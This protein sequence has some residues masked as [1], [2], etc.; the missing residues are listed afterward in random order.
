VGGPIAFTGTNGND[1][2]NFNSTLTAGG[3]TLNA[4]NAVAGNS[5]AFNGNSKI[6]GNV[7]FNGGDS[8]DTFSV[9]AAQTFGVSGNVAFNAGLTNDVFLPNFIAASTIGG[10]LTLTLGAGIEAVILDN[11][12]IV[13]AALVDLGAGNDQ[14]NLSLSGLTTRGPLS[15]IGGAGTDLVIV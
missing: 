8:V 4:G 9:A 14:L 2:L 12:T 1:V 10:S 5:L 7:L 13:G 3:V 11:F 6:A 15:V